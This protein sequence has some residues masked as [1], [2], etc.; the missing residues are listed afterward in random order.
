VRRTT[1]ADIDT[2]DDWNRDLHGFALS[3]RAVTIRTMPWPAGVPC[4]ADLSTPDLAAAQAFYGAVLGWDFD[5]PDGAE[6][7]GYVI[8]QVRGSAAAGL[9]PIQQPGMPSAWTLYVASDDVDAT[10]A[11][12]TEHGGTLVLQ[13]GQVGT[14]GSLLVGLDPTGAP[15]GVWQAGDHIG[16]GIANEPGGLVWEDLRTPDPDR[17]ASFYSGVFGWETQ[18]LPEGGEDYRMFSLAGTGV[19]LGGMGG[20]T[21]HDAP[22]HWLVYF[23]V[24]DLGAAT[25][26]VEAGRGTV[27]LRDF[28]TSY[29]RMAAFTDPAG[30]AF[31]LVETD[32]TGS[33]DRS[34]GAV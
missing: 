20:M 17:A 11:A 1:L 30:A 32:G 34:D 26:A 27:L 6:Y 24:A 9:G 12:I 31:W 3:S 10:A 16:A 18:P 15:F 2:T 13:P 21:G 33:P 25:A 7:G 5:A 23:G 28:R 14:M 4:W 29:G 19:P 22:P 8:A